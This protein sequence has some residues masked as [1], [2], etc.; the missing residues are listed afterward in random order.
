L[1][2]VLIVDIFASILSG[3]QFEDSHV[4]HGQSAGGS[5]ERDIDELEIRNEGKD[6]LSHLPC[7]AHKSRYITHILAQRRSQQKSVSAAV[8]KWFGIER[9]VA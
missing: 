3:W 2:N 7:E 4:R 9:G 6:R 5:L 8:I 1:S